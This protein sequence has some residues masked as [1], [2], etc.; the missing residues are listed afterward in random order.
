MCI[1][2]YSSIQVILF[3]DLAHHTYQSVSHF[4]KTLYICRKKFKDMAAN[5]CISKAIIIFLSI[6]KGNV[7]SKK[8]SI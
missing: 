7:P 6:I 3:N 2:S 5:I 4:S 1:Q 8:H